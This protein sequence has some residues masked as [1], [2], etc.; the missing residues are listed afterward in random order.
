MFG[1]Q[2]FAQLRT[3]LRD[4]CL[5]CNYTPSIAFR[6]LPPKWTDVVSQCLEFGLQPASTV[7]VPG[8]HAEE[9]YA[10]DRVC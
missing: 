6:H 9:N 3:G 5:A 7:V 4:L 1:E 8:W 10:S 2:T